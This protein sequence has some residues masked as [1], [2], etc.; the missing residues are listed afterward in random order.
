MKEKTQHRAFA[1]VW[2]TYFTICMLAFIWPVAVGANSIEPRI[3]GFP[4]FIAW[5]LIWVLLVILGSVS[6]YVWDLQL[7]KKEARHG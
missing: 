6:M 3:A 5:Y 7:S 4:F 2:V 1:G